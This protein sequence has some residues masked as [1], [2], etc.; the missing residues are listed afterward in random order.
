MS[1]SK[2]PKAARKTNGRT[3]ASVEA[4]MK[5]EGI[6]AEVQQAYAQLVQD[7]CI[8]DGLARLRRTAKLTQA[9]IAQRL[10]VTQAAVS[11]IESGHDETL[12]L[13]IIGAYAAASKQRVSLS[14]GR[15]LTHVQAVKEHALG[16]R[17]HL[18]ALASLAHKEEAIAKDIEGFFHEATINLDQ[19]VARC[20][21]QLPRRQ[22]IEVR[23]QTHWPTPTASR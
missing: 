4:L 15:P 19:I 7:T 5:G 23:M 18:E 17:Y 1:S 20:R 3:Y 14:F 16:L 11:K 21:E 8:T 12:T 22:K 6:S 10:G 13:A 2:A 9:E